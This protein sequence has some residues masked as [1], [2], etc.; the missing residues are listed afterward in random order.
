[1]IS[2]SVLTWLLVFGRDEAGG[3]AETALLGQFSEGS[4]DRSVRHIATTKPGIWPER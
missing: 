3:R 2:C 1:L 4:N